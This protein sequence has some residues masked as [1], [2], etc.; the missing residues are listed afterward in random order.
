MTALMEYGL[1]VEA[2]MTAEISGISASFAPL[3]S[4]EFAQISSDAK[5][6]GYVAYASG[7]PTNGSDVVMV[8]RDGTLSR[9]VWHGRVIF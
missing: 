5:G 2:I 7:P 1:I 3:L 9:A 8:R 6:I 4:A